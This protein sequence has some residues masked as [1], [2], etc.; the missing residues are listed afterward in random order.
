MHLFWA[1]LYCARA[2][3]RALLEL[4]WAV[5]T[6][7]RVPI[8]NAAMTAADSSVFRATREFLAARMRAPFPRVP[9]IY[10]FFILEKRACQGRGACS[11]YPS[12]FAAS[13]AAGGS[14]ARFSRASCRARSAI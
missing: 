7:P 10:L 12:P 4:A 3:L 11:D 8:V 1:L 9:Q 13:S 6:L 14:S 2:C 5:K